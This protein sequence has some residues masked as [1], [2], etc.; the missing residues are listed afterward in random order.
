MTKTDPLWSAAVKLPLWVAEACFGGA[1]LLT[2]FLG[3]CSMALAVDVDLALTGTQVTVTFPSETGLAYSVQSSDGITSAWSTVSDIA[4]QQGVT[5]VATFDAASGSQRFY[6]V[7][8][9]SLAA[10]SDHFSGSGSPWSYFNSNDLAASV[11]GG[12][13]SLRPLLCGASN[14]WTNN[15][16]GAS[17]YRLIDGDFMVTTIVHVRG[18]NNP[19]AG[20]NPNGRVA[21]SSSA[22]PSAPA[23]CRISSMPALELPAARRI[24]CSMPSAIQ[25]AASPF[26]PR[27]RPTQNCACA[28]SEIHSA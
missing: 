7:F 20:P 3:P 26:R 28:A 8:I 6:R 27:L 2:F 11:N 1:G 15:Q 25:R 21:G 18:T 5:T 12:Q 22:T 16:D 17:A 19:A 24:S 23:S 9:D 13:L 10:G 4:I 14:A